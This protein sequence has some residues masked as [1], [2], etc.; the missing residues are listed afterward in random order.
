MTRREKIMSLI[1]AG[2]GGIATSGG[3]LN[4]IG[5]SA[6]K[7]WHVGAINETNTLLINLK[8]QDVHT[9][10]DMG[11]EEIITLN[12]EIVVKASN[13]YAKICSLI[14]DIEKYF[15]STISS[16]QTA[17]GY[18]HVKPV[19]SESG[20]DLSDRSRGTQEIAFEIHHRLE[21]SFV[22]PDTKNYS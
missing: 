12:I 15:N 17:F 11:Y 22:G 6:V 8:D 9:F 16:Y 3:Y 1:K 4:T 5:S 21:D 18:W 19:Q 10:T 14:Q 2:I 13:N 7:H 20:I